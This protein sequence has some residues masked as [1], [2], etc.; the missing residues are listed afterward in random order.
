V[1]VAPGWYKDPVEP[2]TQRYW[3]GEGWV[4]APLPADATPPDGPPP[5]E[6]PPPPPAGPATPAGPAAPHPAGPPAVGQPSAPPP[7]PGQPYPGQPYPGQ[8]YPLQPYAGQPSPGQPYPGQPYAG[9]GLPHPGATVRPAGPA[10]QTLAG[11][12]LRLAARLIDILVVLALNVVANGYF[13]YQLFREIMPTTEALNS[14]LSAGESI[15]DVLAS[16]PTPTGRAQVLQWVILVV[17]ALVWAAYEV[18]AVAR[19]GQTFGKRVLGIKVVRVD[20]QEPVGTGR[21]LRRWNVLGVPLLFPFCCV[22]PLI[23]LVDCAWLLF[24]RPLQQALHDKSAQTVVVQV[25][26][27]P[28][29]PGGP[30]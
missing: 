1:T 18:P 13:V 26:R 11:P 16:M 2:T 21:S 30:S 19:T 25:P 29:N 20:G 27:T 23:Q 6:P 5:A 9:P 14:R 24:D 4:G 22:G 12:G 28:H 3:D 10:G 15:G 7:A 17:A 8:P